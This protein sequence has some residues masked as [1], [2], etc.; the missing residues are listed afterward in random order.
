M[1]LSNPLKCKQ[2]WKSISSFQYY[3]IFLLFT[4]SIQPNRNV[5]FTLEGTERTRE[6]KPAEKVPLNVEISNKD[7]DDKRMSYTW[8]SPPPPQPPPPSPCQ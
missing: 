3:D 7:D 2:I 8:D 6:T 1:Y 5:S 4:S